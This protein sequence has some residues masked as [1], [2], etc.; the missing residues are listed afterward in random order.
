[1]DWIRAHAW[2]SWLVLGVVLTTAEMLTLDFTLL[3]LGL[4][5]GVGLVAAL[6]GLP[7]WVQ[8]IAALVSAVL[9]LGLLRP[10]LLRSVHRG[11]DLEVGPQALIGQSAQ[12]LTAVGPG[13]TGRVKIGGDE[14][15]AIVEHDH[16]NIPAG[17]KV[18]VVAINGAKAVVRPVES[19]L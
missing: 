19:A 17:S 2:E 9:L 10:S 6:V 4:A 5:C 3:M 15:S 18:E 7:F 14:W 13:V 1:M 8:V 12:A 16:L 11:E